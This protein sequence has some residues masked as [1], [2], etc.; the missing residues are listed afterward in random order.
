VKEETWCTHKQSVCLFSNITWHKN[1]LLSLK[2]LAIR[3]LARQCWIWQLH[4]G[5][6][7]NF[8]TPKVFFFPNKYSPSDK[9]AEITAVSIANSASAATMGQGCKNSILSLVSSFWAWRV[10]CVPVKVA[11]WMERPYI[12]KYELM[13]AHNT[14]T[15]GFYHSSVTWDESSESWIQTDEV[16]W[17]CWVETCSCDKYRTYGRVDA[18]E[19]LYLY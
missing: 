8:G 17:V 14:A 5:W 10:S 1:Q 9:T 2:H 3:T 16:W 19:N 6:Y 7:Q 4:T 18:C 12:L 13:R 15:V 11:V